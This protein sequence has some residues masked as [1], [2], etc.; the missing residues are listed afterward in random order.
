MSSQDTTANLFFD[1]A[2]L[3]KARLIQLVNDAVGDMDDG[4]LFLEY[5]RAE[6]LVYDDS[7]LKLDGTPG[8]LV[9]MMG[10]GINDRL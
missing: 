1:S 9:L 2:G 4:E 6:S 3:D 10:A 8:G 7:S 5:C